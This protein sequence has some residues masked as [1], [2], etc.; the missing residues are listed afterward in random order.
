[1]I[2]ASWPYRKKSYLWKTWGVFMNKTFFIYTFLLCAF[3]S[4]SVFGLGVSVDAVQT[5]PVKV[6][7]AAAIKVAEKELKDVKDKAKRLEDL[8]QAVQDAELEVEKNSAAP[9]DVLAPSTFLSIK[10][11]DSL[12]NLTSDELLEKRLALTGAL[13]VLKAEEAELNN[14]I[15]AEKGKVDSSGDVV[16]DPQ[17]S[18]GEGDPAATIQL[19]YT[20]RFNEKLFLT[21]AIDIGSTPSDTADKLAAGFAM[22]GGNV[23]FTLRSGYKFE[24]TKGLDGLISFIPSLAYSYSGVTASE[25]DLQSGGTTE[26]DT[27]V[28]SATLNLTVAFGKKYFLSLDHSYHDV[29]EREASEFSALLDQKRTTVVRA[30]FAMDKEAK[31]LLVL[32]RAHPVGNE[33]AQLRLSFIASLDF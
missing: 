24:Y 8:L 20:Y 16:V 1:M 23:D 13:E 22:N 27:E 10:A 25:L 26:V 14:E 3:L 12:T 18:A 15:Y 2:N 6:V 19:R 5:K 17:I 7:D 31:K 9:A 21:S 33:S 32:E 28:Q 4:S 30:I 29:S 11:N